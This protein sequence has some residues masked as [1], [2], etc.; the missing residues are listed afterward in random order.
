MSLCV[1]HYR[2]WARLSL[3][4]S[5]VLVSSILTGCGGGDETAG[6]ASQSSSK[7]GP[8]KAV[9][10]NSSDRVS[11]KN[12][13]PATPDQVLKSF[14]DAARNGDR[15]ESR[16]MLTAKTIEQCALHELDVNPPGTPSMSYRIGRVADAPQIEGGVFVE[17][18]WS[19]QVEDGVFEM[20]VLWAMRKENSQWRICGMV[21][22]IEEE[23]DPVFLDFENNAQQVA[24]LMR[25][26]AENGNS[27]GPAS[28]NEGLANQNQG[29]ANGRTN[30]GGTLQ[31][32]SP[33]GGGPAGSVARDPASIR[34]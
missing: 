8:T 29:A 26:P 13:T 34:R 27:Q 14:L 7:S 25:G 18:T 19:E 17:S 28:S 21:L 10:E 5:L 9:A 6:P 1:A 32:T 15:D 33:T 2:Q 4:T 31:D 22:Q 20:E 12:N 3:A 30:N 11:T 24:A 23:G 16:K